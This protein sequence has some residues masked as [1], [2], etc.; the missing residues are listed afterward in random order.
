MNCDICDNQLDNWL[1]GELS[2]LQLKEFEDHLNKCA[3]CQ[4]DA[5]RA[6]RI[7][8]SLRQLPAPK[9]PVALP[10][11][12]GSPLKKRHGALQFGIAA[13]LLCLAITGAIF[14]DR[15]SN[16][17]FSDDGGAQQQWV[18]LTFAEAKDVTF[19]LS[20]LST[21]NDAVLTLELPDGVQLAGYPDQ[22]ELRWTASLQ[23]GDNRLT[24]PLIANKDNLNT[25][26]L[27]RIEHSGKHQIMRIGIQ[28]DTHSYPAGATLRATR[29]FTA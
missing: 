8:V 18:S 2:A 24:L 3:T 22:R 25:E 7:V 29:G 26:L 4:A 11:L 28:A 23:K 1:D 17:S 6:Q 9:I 19:A 13:S 14:M 5:K 10:G 16:T 27:L 12:L 15:S 21:M 20:S